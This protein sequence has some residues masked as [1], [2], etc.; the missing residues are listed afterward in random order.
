[1]VIKYL[2]TPEEYHKYWYIDIES[3]LIPPEG[4][5]GIKRVWCMC[6]SN[7]ASN[8]VLEFVGHEEIRKFFESLQGQDVYF[9]G[10][11]AISF[12][13]PVTRRVCGGIAD[14]SNTVDTLVLSY[15]YDPQMP[16]GHSLGAWG[17]RMK[18]PKGDWNDFSQYTPEMGRYCA[19]DVKLGK[20]VFK[21][22]VQRMLRTGF[23]EQSCEIEHGIRE[24]EDE[25]QANGWYFDIAGA[26]SLVSTLRSEQSLL[27]APIRTLF[28]PRLVPCNT[29]TRRTKQDGTD[30]ASYIRHLKEYPEVRHNDD[31]T[32]TTYDWEEFNIGSPAQRVSRL[33]ELGYVPTSF[34][35]KTD[36]GGGGNPKVDEETLLAYAEESGRPEVKAIAEWLVL[37]GRATMVEGWL[38]CVNYDDHRMHGKVITC[39][40]ATRRMTHHSPNTANIPKAKAKVKYGIECR[41]LWQAS[42]GRVQVG[43]D[44]SG[45][46][47]RMFAEYLN[48]PVATKLYTEGD[49]HMFNT[50]LLEE[51]DEYRDLAVKNVIYA[52]LYGA[53]D[54]KLGKTAKTSIST[55]KEAKAHGKWVRD[56]LEAGIPGFQ[57]LTSEIKDEFKRNGGFIRTIDG[58]YVRCHAAHAALN[59]K[60]QSA[61]AI[62]MKVAAILAT[63]E[64]KKRGLD[65]LLVGNIHDE[66]Q[67]D[68]RKEHAEEVGKLCVQAIT[69]AGIYL[70][71][72]V[73]LTGEYKIGANW[74]ECH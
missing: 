35:P 55:D 32:Y 10:H 56:K 44:A 8:E 42:P 13:A 62:V 43:C 26:Q 1:M 74:A 66:L 73:P 59:Y 37:Q 3:E 53:Q 70:G 30:Y 2:P 11:N 27:E 4:P 71:F 47:L 46:E 38:N 17:V 29:Y 36:K 69:D 68:V 16:M 7:L 51:P 50:R 15:L 41:R 52:M 22:L 48:D 72:K 5:K 49:P 57:R 63:R 58:G 12:D 9:V 40:A 20:K 34:T 65:A 21:A 67:F 45:L 64:I 28:P 54:L 60:L 61:G 23:S 6:A 19:Q 24:V 25:Q 18:D 31:G 39:G 14:L 33:I